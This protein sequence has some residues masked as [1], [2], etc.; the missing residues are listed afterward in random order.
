M[1]ISDFTTVGGRARPIEV[2]GAAVGE[3]DLAYAFEI[4]AV[5]FAGQDGQPV[6]LLP[7]SSGRHVRLVGKEALR[8]RG[9]GDDSIEGG[10]R[11]RQGGFYGWTAQHQSLAHLWIEAQEIEAF[12]TIL[13]LHVTLPSLMN[14]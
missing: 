5:I 14:C 8:R 4:G 2:D 6:R 9:A 7:A 12:L 1:P 3:P 10:E 11:L 13:C